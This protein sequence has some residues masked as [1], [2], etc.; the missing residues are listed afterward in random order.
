LSPA[1]T[2]K[3]GLKIKNAEQNK[4]MPNKIKNAEQNKKCRTK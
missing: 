1:R 2:T 3:E 4:K